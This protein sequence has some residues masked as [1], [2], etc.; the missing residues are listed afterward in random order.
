[1]KVTG[2]RT[3]DVNA[4]T[5]PQPTPLGTLLL[6]SPSATSQDPLCGVTPSHLLHTLEE[7]SLGV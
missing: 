7:R 1:M 5:P 6:L 3:E 4:N 2:S